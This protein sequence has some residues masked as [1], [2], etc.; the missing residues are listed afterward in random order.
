MAARNSTFK[1]ADVKTLLTE[2]IVHKCVKHVES[3]EK[4]MWDLDNVIEEI[5]ERFI[6][7]ND[8]SSNSSESS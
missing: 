4:S 7:N 2:A 8:E 6:I 3:V 5:E 1:M